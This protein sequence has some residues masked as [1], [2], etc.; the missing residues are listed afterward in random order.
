MTYANQ[1]AWLEDH[2]RWS[3]DCN[4]AVL[5]GGALKHPISRVWVGY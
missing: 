4:A 5:L 2:R 3:N 1:V